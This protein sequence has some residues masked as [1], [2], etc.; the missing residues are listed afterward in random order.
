[1]SIVSIAEIDKE[2]YFTLIQQ[3]S[4]RRVQ[5]FTQSDLCDYLKVSRKTLIEFE[6]GNIYD[7]SL[8]FAY[9]AINGYNINFN[10]E[11]L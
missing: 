6:K 5:N 9:A 8:L 7:I 1:M 10:L 11:N 2:R 3:I 4:C